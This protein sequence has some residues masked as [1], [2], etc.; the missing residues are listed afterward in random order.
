MR[1][2]FYCCGLLLL[3]L[4]PSSCKPRPTVSQAASTPS[5]QAAPTAENPEEETKLIRDSFVDVNSLSYNGYDI[6]KLEKKIKYEYPPEMKSAPL[7]VDVSYAVLKKK[8]QVL[9]R[10]QGVFSGYGNATEFG[11]FPFLGG[12]TKQL[13]VSQTIPRGGRHWIVVL[14]P[15]FQVIYDSAEYGLGREDITVVDVDKDGVYEI[16]QELTTFVFFEDITAGASHL[17]DILLR[18]DER[19]KRYLPASHIFRD[20][21]LRGAE[22]GAA[23]VNRSDEKALASDVLRR[24][25]P[26]IYAGMRNEAWELYDREYTLTNREELKAKIMAALN[27]DAVY[28]YIYHKAQP[29]NGMHPTPRHAV[30]HAR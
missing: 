25:L 12:E 28:K 1:R 29:N 13:V 14:S 26:Y 5:A 30:S 27:D 3:A 4:V 17:V 7:M 2:L 23:R 8:G 11:L 6:V 15:H 9:A 10:F 20:Y 19:S 18:Y 22:G 21:T 16:S 24:M